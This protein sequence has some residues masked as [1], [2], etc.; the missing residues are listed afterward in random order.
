MENPYPFEVL[1]DPSAQMRLLTLSPARTGSSRIHGS[2]KTVTLPSQD[3]VYDAISYAWGVE[4]SS[5]PIYIGINTMRVTKNLYG[6]LCRLPEHDE[7]RVLWID[8]I[9]INQSDNK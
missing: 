8:A 7:P 3:L 4:M 6:A 5:E 1:R 9:C 2:L